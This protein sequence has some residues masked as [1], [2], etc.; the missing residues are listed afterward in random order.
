VGIARNQKAKSWELRAA[1]SLA[2]QWQSDSQQSQ[3]HD[4]LK[5]AFDK[6]S[7]GFD[8]PDL[9]EAKSLL[10]TLSS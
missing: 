4:V 1:I 6:F 7:E 8:T 9:V 5:T 2:H 10:R 3:A